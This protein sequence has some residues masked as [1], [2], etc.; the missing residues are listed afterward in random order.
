MQQI[1]SPIDRFGSFAPD[2]TTAMLQ[3]GCRYPQKPDMNSSP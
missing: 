2:L 3:C 1:V